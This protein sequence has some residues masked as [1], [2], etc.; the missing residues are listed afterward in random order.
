MNTKLI[1]SIVIIGLVVL[2][3]KIYS[4]QTSPTTQT[5]QS[6]SPSPSA[7]VEQKG[8][9]TMEIDKTRGYQAILATSMGDITIQLNADKTPITVNN[10][11]HLARTK[12]Y[13]GTVFH[14][15]IKGFMIQGGDP[16]GNG[17][18][19]PGYAFA[20]EPFDGDYTRGTVA[21][22]NAG[23]NTNGSQFFIIHQ[24][25]SLPKNY[26]IFGKVV[27]GMEVVDKIA[28]SPVIQDGRENSK[29]VTPTTV[30]SVVI[31]EQ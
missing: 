7:V 12:F 5:S 27:T 21:M 23:P 10:F 26:V 24:D 8:P 31:T 14:R 9:P 17:M 30:K 13:D 18:G 1:I 4:M 3:V 6:T 16:Q 22:A 28:D 29:P 25:Y 19:G 15:I 11:V 2:L 20:D